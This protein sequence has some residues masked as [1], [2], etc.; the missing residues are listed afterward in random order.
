ME[1]D[2]WYVVKQFPD[3]TMVY[4]VT[5]DNISKVTNFAKTMYPNPI[6]IPLVWWMMKKLTGC[7]IPADKK[8]TDHCY[9]TLFLP[10]FDEY[11]ILIKAL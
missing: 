6:I 5:A 1:N 7:K 2:Q 3:S 11:N 10:L 4:L 9:G 8:T